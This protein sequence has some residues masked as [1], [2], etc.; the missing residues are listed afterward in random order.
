MKKKETTYLSIE[1]LISLPSLS[2]INVSNNGKKVAY[3]K[4]TANWKENN[5]KE[6]VWIYNEDSRQSYPVPSSDI[7][8]TSPLWAPDSKVL[9]YLSSVEENDHK[10]ESSLCYFCR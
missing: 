5:Y 6:H 1:E 10:K 2:S 9:A 8:S 4:R 7:D 3:V